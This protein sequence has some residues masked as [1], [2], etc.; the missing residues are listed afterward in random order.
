VGDVQAFAKPN[1]D[2]TLELPYTHIYDVTHLTIWV[3]KKLKGKVYEK[4]VVLFIVGVQVIISLL[5][6][7]LLL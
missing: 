2:G 3:L 4:D 7:I 6:I 5:G 1:A